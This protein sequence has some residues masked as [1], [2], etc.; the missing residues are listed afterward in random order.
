MDARV[1]SDFHSARARPRKAALFN[2][3]NRR[4]LLDGVD[5]VS[6][7]ELHPRTDIKARE[8]KEHVAARG[9]EARKLHE[10]I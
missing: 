4:F 9:G 2:H 1:Q 6:I 10:R 7:D 5:R 3:L 8:A